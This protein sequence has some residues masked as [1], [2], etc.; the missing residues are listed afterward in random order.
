M[1]VKAGED[2]AEKG[3]TNTIGVS[4]SYGSQ[5][6]K[7]ETHTESTVSQGSMLNAG[8]NIAI[9]AIGKNKAQRSGDIAIEGSQLKTGNEISLNAAKDIHLTSAENTESTQGHNS[10][11]GGSVGVGLG[12]G[13]GGAGVVSTAALKFH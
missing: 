4:V 13:E 11:K 1:G 7:S 5:S 2:G 8:Q 3:A 6:S 10:S 12:I 9:T